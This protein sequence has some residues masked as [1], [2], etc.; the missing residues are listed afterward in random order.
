[1][2]FQ[3]LAALLSERGAN[4]TQAA[5][6]AAIGLAESGGNPNAVGDNGTSYGIWQIHLPAHPDVTA[7]CAQDPNCAADAVKSISSNFTNWSPW[8]TY[9]SGAYSQFLQTVQGT[10]TQA[11]LL[12]SSGNPI[13]QAI[14]TAGSQVETYLLYGGEF[15]GGLVLLLIGL[16]IVVIAGFKGTGAAKLAAKAIPVVGAIA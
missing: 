8:S 7:Q 9:N 1:M 5:I 15:L 12:S 16:S 14:S 3:E 4:A 10:P 6:G 11:Q 2:T 13:T